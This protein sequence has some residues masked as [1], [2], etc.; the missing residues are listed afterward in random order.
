HQGGVQ[1]AGQQDFWVAVG[2]ASDAMNTWI[3]QGEYG[4]TFSQNDAGPR[5]HED[6][7]IEEQSPTTED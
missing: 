5:E 2:P 6:D 1:N 3:S 7:S 4:R